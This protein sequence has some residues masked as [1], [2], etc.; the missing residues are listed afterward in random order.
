LKERPI[1]FSAPMVRA[2]LEGRKSQTRRIVKPQPEEV[3]FGKNSEVKP[4]CTGTA[5]PLAYYEMRGACWNS[6]Q[7]LISRYG[8]AGDRLWVRET[9]AKDPDAHPA[10]AGPLYR[11][12]DPGWDEDDTHL[13]WKPSLYMPREFS[14]ITLEITDVRVQRVQEI[15][16]EDAKAEGIEFDAKWGWKLYGKDYERL[17]QWTK[18][19]RW[20]Y[21]KLWDEINGKKAP[22]GSN[23]WVWAITFKR[24]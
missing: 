17:N 15:S 19:P 16:A 14:R 18:D 9:W 11:A 4:Y 10:E 12:T 1:L 2:I 20:S 13:K 3:G 21:E 24:I 8:G 6:S 22:W 7:P 23:P 5:W